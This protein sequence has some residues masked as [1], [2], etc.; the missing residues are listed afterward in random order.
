[1]T[2]DIKKI[3]EAGSIVEEYFDIITKARYELTQNLMEFYS[4]N[5][6]MLTEDQML[7]SVYKQVMEIFGSLEAL[8]EES[9]NLYK[10]DDNDEEGSITKA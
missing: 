5:P 2:K 10:F 6:E 7:T 3:L 1:M 8:K 4:E 9:E